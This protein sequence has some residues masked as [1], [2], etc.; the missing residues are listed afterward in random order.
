MANAQRHF[1]AAV[2]LTIAVAVG[3][4]AGRAW[5]AGDTQDP[6]NPVKT[7]CLQLV[8]GTGKVRAELRLVGD[9]PR[10]VFYS[11]D[12]KDDNC[13]VGADGLRV[14]TIS[15]KEGRRELQCGL[16]DDLSG[17]RV[18]W[19]VPEKGDGQIADFGLDAR[20]KSVVLTLTDWKHNRIIGLRTEGRLRSLEDAMP[21]NRTGI[22]PNDAG[23]LEIKVENAGK[24]LW[25][26]P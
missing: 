22:T 16:S 8:D 23:G 5:G 2:V 3:T 19:G 4:A 9:S 15:D 7:D 14:Q 24:P 10:L 25:K 11:K 12:D 6:K 26:A 1:A 20:S 13:S 18:R 21:D 17:C